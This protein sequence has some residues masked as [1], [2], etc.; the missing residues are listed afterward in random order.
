MAARYERHWELNAAALPSLAGPW[1]RE[2]T[3]TSSS[4]RND[5]LMRVHSTKPIALHIPLST[6]RSPT[7]T[8]SRFLSLKGWASP[9]FNGSILFLFPTVC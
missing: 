1:W 3:T 6:C 8:I 5:G 9:S 7:L 4:Q 2:L